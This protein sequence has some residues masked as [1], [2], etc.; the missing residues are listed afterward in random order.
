MNNQSDGCQAGLYL[1]RF[2]IFYYSRLIFQMLAKVNII[3]PQVVFPRVYIPR[4][5]SSVINYIVM[6]NCQTEKALHRRLTYADDL[7][8]ER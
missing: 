6:I 1:T 4:I 3:H 8:I 5:D 7:I 2:P